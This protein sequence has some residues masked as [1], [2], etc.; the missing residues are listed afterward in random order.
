MENRVS[1]AHLEGGKTQRP[2]YLRFARGLQ[3]RHIRGSTRFMRVLRDLGLFDKM[4]RYS[5]SETVSIDIP[6]KSHRYDEW[7]LSRYEGRTLNL[8]AGECRKLTEPVTLIDCG[9]NIGLVSAS[10]V[11]DCPSIANVLAFEP[12]PKSFE[13]LKGNLARR[14]VPGRAIRAGV[15]DFTG[16]GEL[17]YPDFDPH[18]DV[19][20]Y[21]TPSAEGGFPIVTLDDVDLPPTRSLMLKIDV[22]GGE[23][24][25][26]DG[27]ADL[28]RTTPE[29]LLSFE[30]HARHTDRTGIDGIEVLR[31]LE[32][33][34]P[35]TFH[36]SES[37]EIEVT[38]DAPLFEQFGRRS[39]INVVCRSL[40]APEP[41]GRMQ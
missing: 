20:C 17:R 35:C 33:I 25:V 30:V 12:N 10:L 36:I 4:V 3:R 18:S 38:T 28:L 27:A 11:A 29:W 14:P 13:I 39:I 22:E 6:L 40:G 24:A 5:L 15:S 26:V 32:S 37:P 1:W 23:L 31:R 19:A 41:E 7:D 9:A 8:L 16:S 2:W 21:I 34:R